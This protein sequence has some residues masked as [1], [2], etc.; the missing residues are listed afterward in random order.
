MI[1]SMGLPI[2]EGVKTRE[3]MRGGRAAGDA[4]R[5]S[6]DVPGRPTPV[7]KG[8]PER[9]YSAQGNGAD[10]GTGVTVNYEEI[11]HEASDDA[12]GPDHHGSDTCPLGGRCVGSSGWWKLERQPRLAE[13][14]SARAP[15]RPPPNTPPP[16]TT[17]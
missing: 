5:R 12:I 15:P 9:L 16:P 10:P 2:L 7:E 1:D 13:L 6:G 3:T 8:P 17:R 4:F 14:F 11:P